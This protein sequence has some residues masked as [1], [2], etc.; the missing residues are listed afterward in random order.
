MLADVELVVILDELDI[1]V[2][3]AGGINDILIILKNDASNACVVKSNSPSGLVA[4][5]IE[6]ELVVLGKLYADEHVLVGSCFVA[7]SLHEVTVQQD[8]ELTLTRLNVAEVLGY[9]STCLI[10]GE[11]D[12]VTCNRLNAKSFEGNKSL[13]A[14]LLV[15]TEVNTDA[16]KVGEV[17]GVNLVIVLLHCVPSPVISIIAHLSLD[18][19]DSFGSLVLDE[20]SAER[21]LSVEDDA[22]DVTSHGSFGETENFE[23]DERGRF[24]CAEIDTS[25]A[26]VLKCNNIESGFVILL[27]VVPAPVVSIGTLLSL[28]RVNGVI[29]IFGESPNSVEFLNLLVKASDYEEGHIAVYHLEINGLCGRNCPSRLIDRLVEADDDDRVHASRNSGSINSVLAEVGA[30]RSAHLLSDD[31]HSSGIKVTEEAA[32]CSIDTTLFP[33]PGSEVVGTLTHHLGGLDVEGV[34]L[35]LRSFATLLVF[36]EHDVI[37]AGSVSSQCLEL[38]SEVS[39]HFS[40]N[41]HPE[42]IP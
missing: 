1:E 24:S 32:E 18:V 2:V 36:V 29:N 26:K 7:D 34:H 6:S 17:E 12:N 15:G 31:F 39:C 16:T 13:V 8:A 30:F 9:Q 37:N 40:S 14:F 42:S 21:L 19:E 23:G 22:D 20:V 25:A 38:N 4:V 11:A 3:S 28:D 10:D 35:W 41:V 5:V 33:S 27:E